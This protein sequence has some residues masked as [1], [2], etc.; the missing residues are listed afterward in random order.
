MPERPV[1][2]D[3]KSGTYK[4]ARRSLYLAFVLASAPGCLVTDVPDFEPP[5]SRPPVLDLPDPSPTVF[6]RIYSQNQ[7]TVRVDFKARVVSADGMAL[8][9]VLIIDYGVP[10]IDLAPWPSPPAP[11]EGI[12]TDDLA[13]GQEELTL[14]WFADPNAV[15]LGCHTVTMLVTHEF[16]QSNPPGYFCP[17]DRCDFASMTWHTTLCDPN[18]ISCIYDDCPIEGEEGVTFTYCPP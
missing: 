12:G 7:Q 11:G 10:G 9:S 18:D 1:P 16:A 15:G 5:T 8:S 2:N 6:R 13:D 14:S 4:W 3:G 17:K